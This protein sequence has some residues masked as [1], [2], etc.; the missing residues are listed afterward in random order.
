MHGGY[1]FSSRV[2][3][4]MDIGAWAGG[5]SQGFNEAV[6]SFMVRVTPA[7]RVWI[8]AGPAFSDLGY[9]YGGSVVRSGTLQGSGLS[10][11]VG[12]TT[13]RGARWSLDVE[14]RYGRLTYD[15][16]FRTSTAILQLGVS[17][18]P[19]RGQSGS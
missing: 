5:Y 7:S 6:G 11:V 12:A 8:Q 13:V 1:A 3:V 16:G 19:R 10:A 15:P 17:R 14:A 18:G 9:G 2:A 4:L